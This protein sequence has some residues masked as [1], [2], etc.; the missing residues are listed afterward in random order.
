L[1]NYLLACK[2]IP[3]VQLNRAIV[4]AETD[5]VAEAIDS[6]MDIPD[7]GDLLARHYIYPAVLGD[8]YGRAGNLQE[9]RR[10]LEKAWELTPS[11]AEKKLLQEKIA[12][13]A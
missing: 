13:I 7:I 1:Y 8:L 3:I 4:L 11:I 9:S 2:P 6:I 12:A 10:L 5:G